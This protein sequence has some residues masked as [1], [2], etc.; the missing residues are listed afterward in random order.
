MPC[1][2]LFLSV[3]NFYVLQTNCWPTP[4]SAVLLYRYTHTLTPTYTHTHIQPVQLLQLVVLSDRVGGGCEWAPPAASVQS[5]R[6]RDDK[7]QV[8]HTSLDFSANSLLLYEDITHASDVLGKRGSCL[9]KKNTSEEGRDKH[10]VTR[11]CRL[12][13]WLL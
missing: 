7:I 12:S 1:Y 5:K 11:Q 9:L 3:S 2:Q 4:T 10:A 6:F 8:R 13:F